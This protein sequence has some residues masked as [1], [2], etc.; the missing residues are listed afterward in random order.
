MDDEA[1]VAEIFCIGGNGGGG[2]SSVCG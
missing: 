2:S 1:I